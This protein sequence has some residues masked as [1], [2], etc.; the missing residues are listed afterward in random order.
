M[1]IGKISD[2]FPESEPFVVRCKADQGRRREHLARRL[3]GLY[4]TLDDLRHQV[5]LPGRYF[6]TGDRQSGYQL[7]SEVEFRDYR[8]LADLSLVVMGK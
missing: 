6:V 1:I 5:A 3:E 4:Q 2:D 8:Q 7:Q